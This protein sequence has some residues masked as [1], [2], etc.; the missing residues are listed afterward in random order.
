[1]GAIPLLAACGALWGVFAGLFTAV[2]FLIFNPVFIDS[3]GG[4]LFW[5]VLLPAAAGLLAGI[6][7]GLLALLLPSGRE[8][9]LA[10]VPSLGLAMIIVASFVLPGILLGLGLG[11]FGSAFVSFLL[12]AGILLA[13]GLFCAWYV[14]F[15]NRA[16]GASR[17]MLR[18]SRNIA[19]VALLV[20][21]AFWPVS[22]LFRAPPQSLADGGLEMIIIGLDG[23]SPVIMDDMVSR[24]E[25]PTF[26][27]IMDQGCYGELTS[28][29]PIF[30]PMIWTSIATGK[31]PDKHGVRD[32]LNASY[33]D[34]KAKTV[35]EILEEQGGK[36]G[37]YEWLCTWPPVKLN[38]FLVPGWLARNSLTYPTSLSFIKEIKTAGKSGAES[39]SRIELGI[40]VLKA[41]KHGVKLSSVTNLATLYVYNGL[42]K[43]SRP[44]IHYRKYLMALAMDADIFEYLLATEKPKYAF[45]IT[46]PSIP[47]PMSTG[48]ITTPT[49]SMR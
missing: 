3:F 13:A 12:V 7:T 31:M 46:R 16:A 42:F 8:N 33:L 10:A 18:A 28:L 22:A 41:V 34:I 19:L 15:R 48:S 36:T 4:F 40:A 23:A 38:G 25:L 5:L 17:G 49:A 39:A 37:L 47:S 26:A 1:M 45:T 35:W 32:F 6:F 24:G 20:L 9:A 11:L 27:S 29:T 43:P 21:A 44:E 14:V 2:V 30:S